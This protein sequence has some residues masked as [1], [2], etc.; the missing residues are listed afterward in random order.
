VTNNAK[1]LQ[2][3][4]SAAFKGQEPARAGRCPNELEQE[5]TMKDRRLFHLA[6]IGLVGLAVL[7]GWLGASGVL[8][9][10]RVLHP[11]KA[12]PVGKSAPQGPGTGAGWRVLE[13]VRY[14]NLSVF[15]V[16][17]RAG[18]DTSAFLTLDEGLASGQVVVAE[19]GS[20]I[21]RRTRDGRP[22]RVP[23][24]GASVNTLVLINRSSKPLVLLA[25][26]VV[27][28]GKQDRV[29]AKDRV[30]PSGAE[31]LPLDV[32]CVEHGRWSAGSS[33]SAAKLMVHPSVREKAAVERKQDE[34]WSA[35]TRGSTHESV[36]SAP[37]DAAPR[38][39]GRAV[40]GVVAEEA[41]T[42]SY[43][44]IYQS[45]RI[46]QSVESFAAE[47]ERRFARATR[48]L[49][50]ERV[51]GVVIAYGGEVAWADVFASDT[52]FHGYWP[53]LLRSYVVEALARPQLQERATLDD[54]REFLEPLKGRTTEESEPGVYRWRQTTEGRY[55]EI[56]LLTL[57]P[58]SL[59]LHWVKIARTS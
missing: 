29:I 8:A 36:A 10:E 7:L 21:I 27:S 13:P 5:G 39:S 43:R 6:W 20:E 40:A 38:V 41:P 47:V 9:Q 4:R 2:E 46:G 1:T 24:S 12:Q 31:P 23:Q 15:P 22:I 57:I 56:E 30:V 33:F 17:T 34:V 59:T 18:L 19:Q 50:G 51:I 16:V 11:V 58:K 52:L 28:G 54:A 32:F 14:E 42:Q 44:K 35:V 53:K 48:D 37:A 49:K 55:A 3:I 26:E 45:P 25:G